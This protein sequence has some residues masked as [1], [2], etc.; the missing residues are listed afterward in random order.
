M[1]KSNK[2]KMQ[3]KIIIL[4]GASSSGKTSLLKAIQDSFAEPYLDLGIDKFIFSL[5]KRYLERPLW[6]DVLGNATFAGKTGHE[7]I[8]A[9]H[10]AIVAASRQGMNIVADHVLVE[11]SWLQ[12]CAHLFSDLPAWLIGVRCPVEVLEERE[13]MRKNR[14]LGQA[15]A[16]FELVHSHGIYDIEVDTSCQTPQ[17]CSARID[18]SLKFNSSPSAFKQIN[19]SLK[20]I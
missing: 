13:K 14:T 17:E 10:H 2:N 19:L 3:G 6:D 7:L 16:Q 1:E 4:N 18:E 9:M 8:S 15:R 5:P 11:K 12:E 20:S